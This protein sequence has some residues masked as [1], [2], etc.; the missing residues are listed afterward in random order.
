MLNKAA[1]K[2]VSIEE[3][4]FFFLLSLVLSP[5]YTDYV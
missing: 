5:T 3:T 2:I 1:Y 4:H